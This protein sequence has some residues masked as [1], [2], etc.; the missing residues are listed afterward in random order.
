MTAAYRT[1]E[2]P[3]SWGF[4]CAT[5]LTAASATALAA[6]DYM[7]QQLRFAWR[8]VPLPGNGAA[9]DIDAAEAEA[10]CD[11]GLILL[12]VQHCR[13]GLWYA[14]E[15]HGRLD[16]ATAA[17]YAR[18]AGYP[19]GACIALDLESVANSGP[20]VIAHC[21]AWCAAVVAAGYKPVVYVGFSPGLNDVELYQLHFVDRYWSDFGFRHVAVR[22]FCCKQHAQMTI[23]GIQVDP[24]QAFP[25]LLGGVLVGMG[26]VEDATDPDLS[27]LAA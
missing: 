5:K 22:S 26:R 4:D 1:V 17:T 24:D 12:L 25:D 15:E 7:G 11:A 14:S 19:R 8:Y 21:N 9:H 20:P 10:I 27:S 18:V 3:R 13:A 23:A 2:V 6:A 16:G